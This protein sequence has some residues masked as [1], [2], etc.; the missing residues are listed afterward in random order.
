MQ[1]FTKYPRM[2]VTA[3]QVLT[4]TLATIMQKDVFN[5]GSS[6]PQYGI[7]RNAAI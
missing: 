2:Q 3:T 4:V 1:Y 6:L 5:R 7:V